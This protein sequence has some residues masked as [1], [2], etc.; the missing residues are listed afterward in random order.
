MLEWLVG[1]PECQLNVFKFGSKEGA[2]KSALLV[3]V[4]YGGTPL[5]VDKVR[6]MLSQPE[7]I[8]LDPLALECAKKFAA[9]K[10]AAETWK[11]VISLL[12]KAQAQQG[13]ANAE[14]DEKSE[15]DA[16]VTDGSDTKGTDQ[17]PKAAAVQ[18]AEKTAEDT[19]EKTEGD[20]A[21]DSTVDP[22]VDPAVDDPET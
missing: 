2:K 20:P 19:S 5:G 9:P 15:A 4:A 21:E 11:T 6:I 7:R 12:E 17:E 3:A 8:V 14:A 22:T 18:P 10:G 13:E 16:M 1:Q